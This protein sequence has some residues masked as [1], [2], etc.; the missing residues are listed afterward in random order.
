MFEMMKRSNIISLL[1]VL[2]LTCACTFLEPYPAEILDGEYVSENQ[3]TMRGLVDKCYDYIPSNYDDNESAYLDCLTDNAA[4][5]STTST[6]ARFAVGTTRPS[7]DLF[8]TYWSR[9]YKAIYNLNFFI[10]DRKGFNLRYMT[11]EHLDELLKNRLWGEAHALRAWFYWDLLKKFGGRATTGELLGVPLIL[12]PVDITS[13]SVDEL[14]NMEFHRA[15]YD[16]CV[17]QILKDCDTAIAY[18]PKAHRDF[19]V[20]ETR[21]LRV[22]GSRNYG[23]MDGMTATAIKALT[24]LT[25]ASPRFNPDGDKTRWEKAAKY[26]K[27]VMDFKI[28]VDGS[29]SGGFSISKKVNWADPN[30]PSIIYAGRYNTSNEAMERMFY[31]DNFQGNGTMGATQD[32]VDCFGMAD[33]YPIGESPTYEYDPQ[34]PFVNRD[35]RFYS[36]IFYN[37]RTVQTGSA[38]PL[39]N[40][41]FE[42]W[43]NGGKDAAEISSRNS[44]TNYHIKKFVYMGLNWTEK[45][46]QK[47]PRCKF[48]IRWAHMVLAFAEAANHAYGANVEVDGLS[49]KQAIAYL[50]SRNTYDDEPGIVDDPYLEKI[51]YAGE[52]AFD[53]FLRNERRIETCFEGSWFYDIRRWSTTLGPLNKEVHRL[54]V[55]RNA[56]GSFLY[57]TEVFESRVFRSAYL[58]IPY[59]EMLKVKGLVQNEGW[60]SWQ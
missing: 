55:S 13:Q 28:E 56:D 32:F 3:T 24:C 35:P 27:E 26:A 41:T 15:T 16:E 10:Q 34:N 59:T 30:S 42:N 37:G 57:G 38:E 21:D 18:L 40:Y 2:G 54:T 25:W 43:S 50:R 47:M 29:V 1:A 6:M 39:K 51:S 7:A 14:G 52:D 9:D 45:S 4:E 8:A 58:P 36:I 19:L 49:A 48:H 22:L 20:E 60:E 46:V 11:D 5:T 17:E 53:Q 31:P 23:R 33:G 44:R 12:E